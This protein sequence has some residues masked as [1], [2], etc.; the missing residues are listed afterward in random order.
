MGLTSP[1]SLP[2]VPSG[3]FIDFESIHIFVSLFWT[4]TRDLFLGFHNA[5]T[6]SYP[7]TVLLSSVYLVIRT[8]NIFLVG[9]VL[10]S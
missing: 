2:P 3:L 6:V 1:L 4:G 8:G 5:S 10:S 9:A 7:T